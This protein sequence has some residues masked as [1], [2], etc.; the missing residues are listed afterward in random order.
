MTSTANAIET[1]QAS[2]AA[3]LTTK[4]R[5]AAAAAVTAVAFQGC[6]LNHLQLLAAAAEVTVTVQ[7]SDD[8][9]LAALLDAVDALTTVP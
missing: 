3:T 5:G 9:Y 4:N 1:A 8:N 2:I 6:D 7:A